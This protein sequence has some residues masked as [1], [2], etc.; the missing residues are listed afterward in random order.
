MTHRCLMLLLLMLFSS[1][2]ERETS[3]EEAR[4]QREVSQRVE[5]IRTEM[6]ISESRW[7]TARIVCFCLLAGGSLIWLFNG[8]G[9]PSGRG[10]SPN[11]G[12]KDAESPNRRRVIDRPLYDPENEPD[13]YPYRR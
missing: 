5:A 3:R 8:G 1:C 12:D 9:T 11:A 4:F 6:K 10:F 7:H 2:D 13:E